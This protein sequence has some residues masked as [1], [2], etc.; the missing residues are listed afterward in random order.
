MIAT[1][2]W[3]KGHR[4]AIAAGAG[5]IVSIVVA[6][7]GGPGWL[8]AVAATAGAIAVYATPNTPPGSR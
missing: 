4:K 6:I 7:P 3:I 2:A 8:Q 1:E 5:A